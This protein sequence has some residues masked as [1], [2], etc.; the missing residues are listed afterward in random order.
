MFVFKLSWGQVLRNA[1][2]GIVLHRT[3][4]QVHGTIKLKQPTI[5]FTVVVMGSLYTKEIQMCLS[6][7][8]N[9]LQ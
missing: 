1:A 5:L 7:N 4:T 6:L 3:H 9:K 8:K 2:H